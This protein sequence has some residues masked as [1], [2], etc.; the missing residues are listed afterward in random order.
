M[1]LDLNVN[2]LIIGMI[3]L[4][5]FWVVIVRLVRRKYKRE[6]ESVGGFII[7]VVIT[8]FIKW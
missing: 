2:D 6:R 7:G 8:K 1:Y 4:F 5:Y 3:K